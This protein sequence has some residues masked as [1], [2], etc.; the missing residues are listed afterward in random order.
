MQSQDLKNICAEKMQQIDNL[1]KTESY[2]ISEKIILE[3]LK[4]QN[5]NEN[6]FLNSEKAL[7]YLML[8]AK[9]DEQT[10][11]IKNLVQIFDL[12]DF[13]FP[14]NTNRNAIKKAL[15]LYDNKATSNQEI[16][17][18]LDKR[19]KVNKIDFVNPAEI[20]LYFRLF[21]ETKKNF[22][23]Y[24]EVNSLL[25]NYIMTNSIIIENENRINQKLNTT[26]LS[27]ADKKKLQTDTNAFLVTRKN[28][29]SQI[30]N[31]LNCDNLSS[32][33]KSNIDKNASNDYWL[34]LMTE[35]MFEKNC[36]S[37]EIF[38]KLAM[39]SNNIN[40]TS[41]SNYYLAQNYLYKNDNDKAVFYFNESAEKETN[42]NQK[43]SI[44][45]TIA[46][47]IFEINNKPQCKLYL[48]KAIS[49]AP[50][51]G[52]P[53]VFLAELYKA[54]VDEC[55]KNDFEKKAI[56]WLLIET[57]NKANKADSNLIGQTKDLIADAL[58]NI[59]T[60]L[61]IKK[62]KMSEKQLTFNCWFKETILIP[63]K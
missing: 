30:V 32:Y 46:T 25:E 22:Q 24:D 33:C 29:N 34:K 51:F 12:Y 54:S 38:N 52:Q 43:A 47:T 39:Q 6:F 42:I 59:P 37:T 15:L 23:T 48:D 60:K 63:K 18:I 11:Y 1:I 17:E 28:I 4:C 3:S 55:A 41:K 62:A 10:K 5:L 31:F 49:T 57:Y 8:R 50:T 16:F 36:Y 7:H 44:Y 61:E 58:K 26:N 21:V 53:Y 20:N 2:F 40:S 27:N 9:P 19:I 56:N 14:E 13:N 35:K 45:Y